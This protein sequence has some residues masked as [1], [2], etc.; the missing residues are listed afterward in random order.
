MQ[1]QKTYIYMAY[2]IGIKKAISLIYR[3]VVTHCIPTNKTK[4]LFFNA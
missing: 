4:L 3:K 1:A 2:L